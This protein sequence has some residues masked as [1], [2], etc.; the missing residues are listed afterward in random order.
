MIR[1]RIVTLTAVVFCFVLANA[2]AQERVAKSPP[3]PFAVCAGGCS[4]SMHVVSN[5]ETAWE[6]IRVAADLRRDKTYT[7]VGVA[8]GSAMRPL[9]MHASFRPTAKPESVSVYELGCKSCILRGTLTTI[10][11]AD[12][13]A[14]KITDDDGVAEVVFN[15]G[16]KKI[17]R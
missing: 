9:D 6:A 16:E 11:D 8:K 3:K 7:H 5:H 1:N 4:R 14:K 10:A 2:S 12:F 17:A 13:L 15:Y